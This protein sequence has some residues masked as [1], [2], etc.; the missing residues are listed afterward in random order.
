MS[1]VP[2]NLKI[3][4]E[5]LNQCLDETGAPAS[6]RERSAILS[7]MINI[8]KPLARSLIEGQQIPDPATLQEIA[9]EFDIDPKW[10][11]GES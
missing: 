5:R 7:K 10:L 9:K 6:A 11:T 3:F 4:S 2:Q 8:P 1:L